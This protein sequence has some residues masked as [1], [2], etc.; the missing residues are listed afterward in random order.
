LIDN[1][2]NN[3]SYRWIS[4]NY[5]VG[6]NRSVKATP[7]MVGSVVTVEATHQWLGTPLTSTANSG[8]IQALPRPE[9]QP[10][11]Q[12]EPQPQPRAVI[13]PRLV[14]VTLKGGPY[15][16]NAI[17]ATPVWE[18]DA[19]Q[20]VVQWLRL[21]GKTYTPITNART[22]AYSPNV[23]DLHTH[24]RVVVQQISDRG[25]S[26]GDAI[27][28]NIPDE[29][30][31][32]SPALEQ[33]VTKAFKNKYASFNVKSDN[34][35]RII[36]VNSKGLTVYDS[37]KS[38]LASSN[39]DT[40]L[41]ATLSEFDNTS[42]TLSMREATGK[43]FTCKDAA[44]RDDVVLTIRSFLGRKLNVS[45]QQLSRVNSMVAKANK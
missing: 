42:F 13:I 15:H 29:F 16:T 19:G 24:L 28:K 22:F 44:D 25:E 8:V 14:D 11:P 23:D 33:S 32:V 5:L 17:I 3:V 39:Y 9:P 41:K 27:E 7:A 21:I 36:Q 10:Q 6:T 37:K 34:Q 4:K 40:S 45:D 43:V 20:A 38:V 1:D 35:D 31:H 2:V 12:P 18:S 26:I 30:L